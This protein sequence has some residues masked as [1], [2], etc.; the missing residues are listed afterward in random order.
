VTERLLKEAETPPEQL[1]QLS[2]EQL[3]RLAEELQTQLLSRH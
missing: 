3:T 1:Q 2:L